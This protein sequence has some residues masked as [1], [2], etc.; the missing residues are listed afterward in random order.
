MEKRETSTT[1]GEKHGKGTALGSNNTTNG[2]AKSN[3]TNLLKR[4]LHCHIIAYSQ[5][6]LPMFTND[7]WIKTL[8]T[9]RNATHPQK[10]MKSC[11]L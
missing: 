5:D 1:T 8:Y 6:I 2:I 10:R 7:E 3:E 4:S 11:H 9:Q